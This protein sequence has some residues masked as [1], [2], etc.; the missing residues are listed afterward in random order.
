MSIA[1][2]DKHLITISVHRDT[3]VG[4]V[5]SI[6]DVLVVR[7]RWLVLAASVSLQMQI[8]ISGIG[9]C[10]N[11]ASI[12]TFRVVY[13][14]RQCGLPCVDSRV[15]PNGHRDLLGQAFFQAHVDRVSNNTVKGCI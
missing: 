13:P 12:Y 4:S 5:L 7:L 2:I 3:I 14:Y 11:L 10:P 9:G 1:R 15:V 8:G 6:L